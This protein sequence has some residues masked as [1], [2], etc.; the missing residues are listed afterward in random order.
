MNNAQLSEWLAR[1]AEAAESGSLKARAL[2]RAA[3]AALTWPNEVSELV[4]DGVPL[5]SLHRVGPFVAAVI[6]DA[7]ARSDDVEPDPT[8]A[9]FLTRSQV[10]ALLRGTELRDAVH[11]DFQVHTTWSDG[12]ATVGVM[13]DEAARL[14]SDPYRHHR[15]FERAADRR[16]ER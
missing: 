2:R 12:H 5:T 10:T 16:R 3:R 1:G 6:A 14:R 15:P 8:R 7:M 4:E 13:A 11:A 9:R